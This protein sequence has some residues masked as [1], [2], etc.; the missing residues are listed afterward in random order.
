[1]LNQYEKRLVRVD[2]GFGER[3]YWAYTNEYRQLD[4]VAAAE[5][6]L[7]NTATEPVNYDGRDYDDEVKV[8]VKENANIDEGHVIAESLG[9]MANAYSAHTEYRI[10]K[11]SYWKKVKKAYTKMIPEDVLPLRKR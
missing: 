1:M 9:G 3:E 10:R 4:W 8:P 7:Q 11:L 6:I 2:S 5:I